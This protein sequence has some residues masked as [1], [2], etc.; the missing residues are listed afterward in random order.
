MTTDTDIRS[1]DIG[2]Y[3]TSIHK[4]VAYHRFKLWE[5]GPQYCMSV[6]CIIAHT[7]YSV[8][9]VFDSSTIYHVHV[10]TWFHCWQDVSWQFVLS[11]V[12]LSYLYHRL[13]INKWWQSLLQFL[14]TL[15]KRILEEKSMEQNKL[16]VRPWK[17]SQSQVA[18][19]G[20]NSPFCYC[21]GKCP[22][23]R[24]PLLVFEFYDG[25]RVDC[26]S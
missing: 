22:R 6:F 4:A 15:D 3:R 1:S 20:A 17:P 13:D 10:H 16:H 8:D 25:L 23:R 12:I 21:K 19:D 7:T 11:F 9:V 26:T 2:C 5:T 18:S 24:T 14:P